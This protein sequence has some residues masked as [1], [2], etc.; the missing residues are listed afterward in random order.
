MEQRWPTPSYDL[1]NSLFEKNDGRFRGIYRGE[2]NLQESLQPTQQTKEKAKKF[3]QGVF[4]LSRQ[5]HSAQQQTYNFSR[6][7]RCIC[8]KQWCSFVLSKTSTKSFPITNHLMLKLFLSCVGHKLLSPHTHAHTN[9][10][11]H[12]HRIHEVCACACAHTVFMKCV[13]VHVHTHTHTH[14]HLWCW[15]THT[16]GV[17][18][19]LTQILNEHFQS[20]VTLGQAAGIFV[21]FLCRF[22]QVLKQQGQQLWGKLGNVRL[23]TQKRYLN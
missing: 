12:P 6:K 19:W 1:L 5:Q 8:T 21:G 13:H 11:T 17:D 15:H 14:A 9:T 18:C 23:K 16:Y 7:V 10:H 22:A 20:V 3:Q 2:K 4:L